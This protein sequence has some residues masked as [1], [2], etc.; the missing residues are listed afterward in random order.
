MT[1][2][3]CIVLDFETWPI[4]RRPDY[5][6]HPAGI[7]IR[8]PGEV[9][10]Y[11]ACQHP[12]GNN[13]TPEEALEALARAWHH[14]LPKLFHNAKFDV[15]V[16]VEKLGLPMLPWEMIHDTMFSAFLCD[17][18]ASQLGLKLLAEKHLGLPPE[19]RDAVADWVLAHKAQLLQTYPWNRKINKKT[20]QPVDNIAPS[21]VGAWIFAAPGDVVGPYAVGDLDRTLGLHE[22]LWPVVQDN[23]MGA[24]YDR[25][26]RLMPILLENERIGI[27]VD[28]ERLEEEMTEPLRGYWQQMHYTED[29][30]RRELRASGLNFDADADVAS[31]LLERGIVPADNWQTTKDG[32]MSMSKDN[33]R[34]EH[35]T[36]PGG[37]QLASALGY[38]NR[39]KTCLT[40]FMRPWLEQAQQNG[41]YIS[42]N[43]NQTRGN[44]GGTRTGRPSTSD[45]NLLNV[46]K[47]WDGRDDG[48]VHP[49]FLGVSPLPLCRKYLGPDEGE[50]F[51]HRDFD[52]Q[53]LR[54]FA[55][56]EQGA[57]WQA[58]NED[59]A[60][61]PHKMVGEQMMLVS[62]REIDRTKVKGLNFQGIYGG[63]VNALQLKLRI[64]RTEAQ[65]L[66]SFHKAALPGLGILNEE[67]KRVILRGDAIR[68]TGGRLYFAEP[69]GWS[70]KHRRHMDYLYKLINYYC[71]GSAADLT[72][73]VLIQWH[74]AKDR[75]ARFLVTVY[76]EINVS[77]ERG[78]AAVRQMRLLKEIMEED[79]LSVPM[80][81]SPKHGPTWGDSKKCPAEKGCLLCA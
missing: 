70:K 75:S 9:G 51:L 74:S 16:A 11:Y 69:A 13:C 54:I 38:R 65:E 52:G 32:S 24:A 2:P 61:D 4:K 63:G 27:R 17:P 66:K 71:Q 77:S 5:P 35:F 47:S 28:V 79:R 20:G 45:P 26:R 48:Y 44:D 34:P 6:P 76:D 53:E 22:Y 41:G 10:S 12:T 56:G 67:I 57:L 23:G 36:G 30:M 3:E 33:L 64:S 14:P 43:W 80:R 49:A 73:E 62:G 19:E 7:A 60:L 59:P 1:A 31:V 39:L 15:A 8:W 42:T 25:E 29:W 58:F 55:H 21:D 72:K 68:T 40:M 46:S 50:E 37:A 78:S 81:S 18:H